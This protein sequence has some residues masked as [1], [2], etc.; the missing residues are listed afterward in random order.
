MA[1]HVLYR[2]RAERDLERLAQAVTLE[3][4]DALLDA[5]ESLAEFPERCAFAPEPGFRVR[6]IPEL[7]Y[8]EGH[9]IY[10]ILYRVKDERLQI[11]TV[12]HARRRALGR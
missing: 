12:R 6:G 10:R 4:F 5:I 8:G 9:N 2:R 7:L 1:Y 11:L 3:W